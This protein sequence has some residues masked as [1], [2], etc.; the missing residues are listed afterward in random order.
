VKRLHDLGHPGWYLAV[1]Y[2]GILGFGVFSAVLAPTLGLL[3]IL[4]M[5][6]LAFAGMWYSIKMAFFRGTLGPNAFGPDPLG[7]R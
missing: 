7:G 3:M 2:G 6:V 4:P 5:M 1:I